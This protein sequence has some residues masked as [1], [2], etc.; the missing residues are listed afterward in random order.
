MA[1]EEFLEIEMADDTE[2]TPCIRC[3]NDSVSLAFF[4]LLATDKEHQQ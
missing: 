2:Q 3:F 4:N 1:F